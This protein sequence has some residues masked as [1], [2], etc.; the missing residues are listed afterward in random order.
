M[1]PPGL[2]RQSLFDCRANHA[3]A[4]RDVRAKVNPKRATAPLR[5]YLE[6][7][8]RLRRLD[9]AECVCLPRHRQVLRVV[10]RDLQEHS[11][12]GPPL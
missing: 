1:H 11:C 9:D 12:V 8:A 5:Q 3:Q 2:S 6:I 10:A 7:A 4:G